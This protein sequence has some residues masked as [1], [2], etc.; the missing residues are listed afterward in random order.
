M[1]ENEWKWLKIAGKYWKWPD[2]TEMGLKL[3]DMIANG[4]IWLEIGWILL[5]IAGKAGNGV[6]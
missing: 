4:S 5:E 3:L 2:I 6:T 1:A